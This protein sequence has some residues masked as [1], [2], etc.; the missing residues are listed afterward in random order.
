[1]LASENL[2]L[3]LIRRATH[4]KLATGQILFQQ[5]DPT[6]SI[7]WVESGRLRLVS[8]TPKHMITHYTV[9]PGESFAETALYF[10]TYACTVIAEQDSRV[11]A[12]PKHAFL[13]A[14][15]QSPALSEQYL[16]HLTHRFAAVKRLVELRSIRSAY[17][18][19]LHYLLH[20]RQPGQSTIS[21]NSS[22]KTLA[23]E[24]GLTPESLSRTFTRLEAD[25]IL[26]R[27][28]GQIIF[29]DE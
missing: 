17:D 27:K 20:Q 19:L 29:N 21:L 13:E 24:L 5:G 22:L 10:D 23:A 6:Q 25:Q 18:R 3:D 7:F 14:V 11:I 12:I 9:G 4:H 16:A 15:R 2:P 28:R 8:F 1:M 26:S